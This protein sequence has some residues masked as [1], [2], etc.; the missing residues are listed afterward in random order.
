MIS[1]TGTGALGAA[2]SAVA[3]LPGSGGSGA[4]SAS[5][6]VRIHSGEQLQ[7]QHDSKQ[8]A[9]LRTSMEGQSLWWLLAVGHA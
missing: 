6:G 2:G 1:V 9:Q 3:A 5:A 4:S 7:R 8:Q